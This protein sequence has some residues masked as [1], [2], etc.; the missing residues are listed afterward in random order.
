M[1][2]RC[3]ALVVP[4]EFDS[5]PATAGVSP[6]S[7]SNRRARGLGEW[8]SARGHSASAWRP[9]GHPRAFPPD[10]GSHRLISRRASPRKRR[11]KK[12]AAR[13][14]RTET[15]ELTFTQGS[16]LTERRRALH[17][18]GW[19]NGLDRLQELMSSG[20]SIEG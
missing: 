3:S 18:E 7:L 12:R 8:R 14:I 9:G 19:T 17:E 4:Y 13:Q 11:R 1:L 20:A 16:F 15:T 10:K 5:A 6:V 2:G